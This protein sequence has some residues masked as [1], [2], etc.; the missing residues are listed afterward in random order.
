M[1]FVGKKLVG[2][3][4][5]CV[6]DFCGIMSKDCMSADVELFDGVIDKCVPIENMN[7]MLV[8][9]KYIVSYEVLFK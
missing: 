7:A 6:G 8:N 9:E 4:K 5:Y 3:F 1:D 2:E